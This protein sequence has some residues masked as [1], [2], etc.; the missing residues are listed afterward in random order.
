MNVK[1]ASARATAPALAA[2]CQFQLWLLPTLENF[3]AALA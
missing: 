2:M 3:P 1:T